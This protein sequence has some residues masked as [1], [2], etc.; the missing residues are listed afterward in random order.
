MSREYFAEII[1]QCGGMIF[2]NVR[3]KFLLDL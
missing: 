2:Q 1:D 3:S